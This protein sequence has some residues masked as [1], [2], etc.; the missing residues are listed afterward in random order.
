[1]IHCNEFLVTS[2]LQEGSYLQAFAQK[3][4]LLSR[5]S[6]LTYDWQYFKNMSALPFLDPSCQSIKGC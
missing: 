2:D 6:L 5:K 1:M 3:Q 4:I